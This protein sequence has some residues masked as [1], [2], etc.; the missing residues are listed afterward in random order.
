MK[1]NYN[2][3]INPP[4]LSS[5][6]INQHQDFDALLAS[7]EQVSGASKESNTASTATTTMKVVKTRRRRY[8]AGIIATLAAASLVFVI[9]KDSLMPAPTYV[10]PLAQVNEVLTLQSPMPNL[11]PPPETKTVQA[12][13]GETLTYSSGS[14]VKIPAAAFV[15][16]TGQ[17]VKGAVEITYREFNDPVDMF[18]A[19]I[20]KELNKH[21][22]LRSTGMMEIKGFQNGEPVYL[23]RNKTLDIELQ[24]KMAP[25]MKSDD[26]GVY[27]YSSQ[28]DAWNYQAKDRVEILNNT[29]NNN[30]TINANNF[31]LESPELAAIIAQLQ[32]EKQASKPMPPIKPGVPNDMQVFDFELDLENAPELKQYDQKID[33]M[34]SAEVFTPATFDTIWSDMA[35]TKGTDGHY[36]L[37]LEYENEQGEITQKV[38]KVEPVVVATQEAKAKFEVEQAK[39][40]QALADW[41]TEIVALAQEQITKEVLVNIINRFEIQRFGLWNCG[42]PVEWKETETVPTQFVDLEGTPI[43]LQEV[44]VAAQDQQFYYS[45][46]SN[47]SRSNVPLPSDEQLK[48]KIWAMTA[49]GDLLVAEVSSTTA[50]SDPNKSILSMKP[51]AVPASAADLRT[52]LT[53]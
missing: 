8:I 29:T 28:E 49:Q 53:L 39:Y 31:T 10:P 20:P 17:P 13:T 42:T 40:Q 3:K 1:D 4:E 33:F 51:V 16:K 25:D 9:F 37:T 23:N 52:L 34:A 47:Q 46:P 35:L 32:Q 24:G 50:V 22:D 2:I 36:I 26:L 12:E 41:E 15:D 21:Q 18:L 5:E 19:G 45:A 44:F 30:T 43:E 38:A 27:V 48:Q 11:V 14:K 7:F 6:Q